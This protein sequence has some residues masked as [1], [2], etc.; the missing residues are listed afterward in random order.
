MK[1]SVVTVC[2]NAEETIAETI[3]SVN[4]Q[5]YDD[6]EHLIFDGGSTDKTIDIINDYNS[7]KIRLIQGIDSGI[8]DALNQA[9]KCASG[10]YICFL[11]AD[12]LF[13]SSDVLS[14]VADAAQRLGVKVV[15]GDLQFVKRNDTSQIV[16]NWVS[17]SFSIDKVL[18]GWMPPT[19][20]VFL[21]RMILEEGDLFDTRYQISGDYD[22]FLRNRNLFL[23]SFYIEKVFVKMR[24]GGVSN[25]GIASYFKKW[26]E[27]ARS[28]KSNGFP[29]YFTLFLKNARKLK[30]LRH[31]HAKT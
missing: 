24:L 29:K 3:Q 1:L 31:G 16:R 7:E 26:N 20:T 17:G 15:Y 11:N 23:D 25:A 21:N 10:K 6:Y 13:A 9:A 30:Q 8:Y 27:D 22:F 18:Y 2:L 14:L 28:L 19:P 4:S 12:D 5:N